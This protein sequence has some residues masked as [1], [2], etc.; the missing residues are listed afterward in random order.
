M[1]YE[2]WIQTWSSQ[3]FNISEARRKK[4]ACIRFAQITPKKRC[5]PN[6]SS[7]I[8][9]KVFRIYWVP[10][11]Q[12]SPKHYCLC[13]VENVS[14]MGQRSVIDRTGISHTGIMR[15]EKTSSQNDCCP[16]EIHVTLFSLRPVSIELSRPVKR[17]SLSIGY[18][19]VDYKK[20]PSWDS[21]RCLLYVIACTPSS[22]SSPSSYFSHSSL[23]S[24]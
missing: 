19:E 10:L 6:F 9:W 18:I 7:Y 3:I 1:K 13:Q 22:S 21:C 12:I 14:Y 23:I 20:N 17:V 4:R 16:F 24:M 15:K 2:I 8:G 5:T 11:M